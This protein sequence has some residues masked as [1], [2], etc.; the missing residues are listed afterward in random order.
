VKTKLIVIIIIGFFLLSIFFN[1]PW[2]NF[3]PSQIL[4]I[5]FLWG[6]FA[7][8]ILIGVPI[9]FSLGISAFFT[10]IYVGLPVLVI[11]QSLSMGIY[12]FAY[13]AI[14]FFI[15]MG[16]LMLIG[17]M[18]DDLLAFANIFV[19]RL[20]GG[21]AIVN[22]LS[23]MLLGGISGSSVADVAAIGS[24]SI[25]M[26]EKQGYTR[27]F[28][29]ALTAAASQEGII[30]PPS[31][32]MI[33]YSLAAGGVSVSGLFLAGYI[34]GILLGISLIVV[35]LVLAKLRNFPK[36]EV[37][38]W[39][40]KTV[41]MIF[42]A[43]ISIAVG[44]LTV[45]GIVFGLFTPTESA[46]V[47]ALLVLILDFTIY[48]KKFKF[49][50]F[51]NAIKESSRTTIMVL[52]L[53]ANASAFGYVMAYLQVPT[54][55]AQGIISISSNPIIILLMINILLLALGT[56][57]DMAPLIVIMTPILLPLVEKIGMSPIQF[58]ILMLINL[59]IG[60][61]TPPV[62]NALFVS[63]A[64]GK[65]TIEKETKEMIL[66][67]I[68]MIITLFLVTYIPLTSMFI[69]NLFGVR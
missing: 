13:V 44:G 50:K 31:Q 45:F 20:P 38:V 55:L 61:C 12:S 52:F 10:A 68:G 15:L 43:I 29:S 41:K 40:I 14:P 23:N 63:S 66:L 46:S 30:I 47:G 64:I 53:I 33:I 3:F 59:G 42:R 27:E 11:F 67:L 48:R 54:M 39:D 65:V 58:G 2:I 22:V 24:V 1:A 49:S 25:P 69:P 17:G 28:S 35:I 37:V 51:V 57:M 6:T 8:F 18:S 9:S 34:P 56:V 16:Q 7:A 19:G 36:G 32:N 26:M 62:G 4:S 5:T 60:L 21:F